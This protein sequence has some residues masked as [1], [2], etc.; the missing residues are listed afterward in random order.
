VELLTRPDQTN[1]TGPMRAMTIYEAKTHLSRVVA[2]AEEGTETVLTR[3]GKPVARVV[4]LAPQRAERKP[5]A[6][7]GQGWIADDFD[8]LTDAELADWYGE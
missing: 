8:E 1:H 3:H 6:F 5:G 2:L 4:P 7:E